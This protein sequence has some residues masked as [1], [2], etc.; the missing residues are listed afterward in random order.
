[1]SFGINLKQ[2]R[3][4][5]GLTQG[6]LADK[7]SMQVEQISRIE[8]SQNEPKLETIIKICTALQCS[9]DELI[10]GKNDS[11][12][13]ESLRRLLNAL[14]S[15]SNEKKVMTIEVLEALVM[16]SDAESWINKKT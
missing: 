4:Q 14:T 15:L 6:Q 3:A 2:L 5:K 7:A 13:D 1:M 16:K 9:S 11:S 12:L 8:R 10:F